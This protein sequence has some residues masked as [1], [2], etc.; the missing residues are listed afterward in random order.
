METVI[1][2][3]K[4]F[5][6]L[7]RRYDIQITRGRSSDETFVFD[8]QVYV[9]GYAKYLIEYLKPKFNPEAK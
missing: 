9:M 7:Q 6:R 4:K 2:D 8:G 3:A 5:K 1:W